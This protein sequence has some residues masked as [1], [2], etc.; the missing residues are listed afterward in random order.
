MDGQTVV[1]YMHILH[2]HTHGGHAQ[3]YYTWAVRGH[4][5]FPEIQESGHGHELPTYNI[6]GHAYV[7]HTSARVSISPK[8][9]VIT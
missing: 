5:Y 3:V 7:Y 1:Y 9:H 4:A 6:C 8:S 2:G